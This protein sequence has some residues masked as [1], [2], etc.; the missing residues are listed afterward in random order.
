[1]R[2]LLLLCTLAQ[3]SFLWLMWGESNIGGRWVWY[4]ATVVSL[5]GM[6]LPFLLRTQL[7]LK[8][9]NLVPGLLL[10]SGW[11]SWVWLLIIESANPINI[12]G[13]IGPVLGLVLLILLF[14]LSLLV[15][16]LNPDPSPAPQIP[17]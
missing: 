5:L 4:L 8:V 1:M 11:G 16:W 6:L 9:L 3:L 17:R 15:S 10:L 14:L 2:T 7:I 13:L 12:W